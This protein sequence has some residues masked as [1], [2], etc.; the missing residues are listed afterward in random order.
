MYLHFA[1][2]EII[3]GPQFK[4]SDFPELMKKHMKDFPG[5]APLETEANKLIAANFKFPAM[6]NYIRNVCR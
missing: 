1:Q 4:L 5:V 3:I 6:E 2:Q